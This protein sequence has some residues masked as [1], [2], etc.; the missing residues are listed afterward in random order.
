MKFNN[1]KCQTLHVEWVIVGVHKN[2]GMRGWRTTLYKGNLRIW[3]H[4]KLNASHQCTLAAKGDNLGYIRHSIMSQ[5]R[6][7]I[8]SLYTVVEQTHLKYCIQFWRSQWKNDIKLKCAQRRLTKMVKDLNRNTWKECLRSLG[9]FISENKMLRSDLI[10]KGSRLRRDP[11]L[12][13][14]TSNRAR[15]NGMSW[16]ASREV[17]IEQ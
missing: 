3:V 12:S 11:D 17:Q 14:V 16:A 15:G 8:V 1:S 7:V 9:L 4:G 13:L 2:W 6:E 5:L 10:L